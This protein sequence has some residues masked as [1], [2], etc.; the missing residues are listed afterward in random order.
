MTKSSSSKG[1]KVRADIDLSLYSSHIFCSD[2]INKSTSGTF[3]SL[4]FHTPSFY[5]LGV[6]KGSQ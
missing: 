6:K 3:K 2:M 4:A 5:Q 1:S